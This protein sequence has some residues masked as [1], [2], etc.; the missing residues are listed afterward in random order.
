MQ[1]PHCSLT[2]IVRQAEDD[3]IIRLSKMAREGRYIPYGRYGENV[4][5]LPKNS[6]SQRER[7][8]IFSE[9]DQ[10]ICG[11]N[12]TRNE[13]NAEMRWYHGIGKENLLP[14]DGEKV[15]CTLNDWEKPLDKEGKFHLVNGVIGI[16]ENV[17]EGE[18]YLATMDFKA[19]FAK[20]SVSVPFDTMIFTDGQ[21]AH[22]YGD[23]AVRLIN[24]TVAHENNYALLRKLK[25]VGE[26]PICRFEFA[27]AITCHK[28]QG[29]E[30]DSVVVFDESWAFGEE[31]H[32][33]LYTAITRAK[34]KLLIIR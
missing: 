29:S 13:L 17:Q 18:D 20:Y 26:E 8:R 22:Y 28:A 30:F 6:L 27:Y 34:K 19:D 1:F 15:I 31:R 11:R 9:T 24:G 21:Y 5:V 3:P 33:W 7:K 16:C 4:C 23:R 32:K 25:A 14:L 12:K 2:E 10:V